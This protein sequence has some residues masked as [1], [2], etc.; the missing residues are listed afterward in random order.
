M[1][2]GTQAGIKLA[3]LALVNKC[4]TDAATCV[5]LEATRTAAAVAHTTAINALHTQTETEMASGTFDAS[6]VGNYVALQN[7]CVSAQAELSTAHAAAAAG[8]LTLG[9]DFEAVLNSRR[10]IAALLWS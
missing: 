4:N 2:S 8:R 5:T 9:D 7:A 6:V 1:N 10:A 3:H